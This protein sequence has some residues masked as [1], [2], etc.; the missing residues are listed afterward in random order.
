MMESN[1]WKAIKADRN[2]SASHADRGVTY[3]FTVTPWPRTHVPWQNR[4]KGD[5]NGPRQTDLTTVGMATHKQIE[6]GMC[7]LAVD[8]RCMRQQN[9]KRDV[10]NFGRRLFDVVDPIV[11]RIVNA[12]QVNRFVAARN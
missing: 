2:Y 10:W 8:F 5:W 9:R 4:T 3:H 6:P 1:F 7:S 12:G 11:V